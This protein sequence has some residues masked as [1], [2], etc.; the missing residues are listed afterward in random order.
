MRTVPCIGDIIRLLLVATAL[1]IQSYALADDSSKPERW[2]PELMIR[3][4]KVTQVAMS[5]DGRQVVYA[6]RR[7]V[8][9]EYQ[10]ENRSRIF[11]TSLDEN[12]I[13]K[14]AKPLT[15]EETSCDEPQWSPDGRAI[16]FIANDSGHKNLWLLTGKFG[17]QD[18]R[19]GNPISGNGNAGLTTESF[20]NPFQ[21]T[22]LGSDV[23]TFRWSPNGEFI[24]FT[25]IEGPSA[26][27]KQRQLE[28]N[29]AK[30]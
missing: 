12:G 18:G 17:Q 27:E 14:S 19:D 11:L 2:S 1:P 15:S 8:I 4:P 3:V 13:V 25:S 10:S 23:G 7:A 28:K 20:N 5:P 9:D 21:F 24:A 26:D 30:L 29:D 22:N 16:A 6:V